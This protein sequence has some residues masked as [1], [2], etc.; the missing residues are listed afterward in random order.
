MVLHDQVD[1]AV[2]FDVDARIAIEKYN[3]FTQSRRCDVA[4]R[5]LSFGAFLIE[6]AVGMKDFSLCGQVYCTMHLDPEHRVCR[7]TNTEKHDNDRTL[8]T[9][10]SHGAF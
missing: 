4:R 8:R 9:G 5:V 3:L 2:Q 6:T 10:S 1:H 7:P